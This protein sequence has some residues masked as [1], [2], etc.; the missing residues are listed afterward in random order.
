MQ[1]PKKK[2]KFGPRQYPTPENQF[3]LFERKVGHDEKCQKRS[4]MHV[5]SRVFSS[6]VGNMYQKNNDIIN[7]ST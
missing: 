6:V 4:E 1:F 3:L 2:A 5:F 7:Y